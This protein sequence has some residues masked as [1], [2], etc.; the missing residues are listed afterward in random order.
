[1][2]DACPFGIFSILFMGLEIVVGAKTQ[3][4][5]SLRTAEEA[6]LKDDLAA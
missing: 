1:M 3:Y 2:T 4:V 5:H 6:L